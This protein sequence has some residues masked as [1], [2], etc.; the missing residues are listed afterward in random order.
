MVVDLVYYIDDDAGNVS[1]TSLPLPEAFTLAQLTEFAQGFAPIIDAIIH[2]R[3]KGADLCVNINVGGLSNNNISTISDVEEI[4]A[5]EFVTVNGDRV[6][7]NVPGCPDLAVLAGSNEL[8][9]ADAEVAA[10]ITMMESGLAVTSGTKEP[11]DVGASDIV[12]TLFAREH[13]RSSGR[14]R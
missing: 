8:D 10:V 14:R 12:D 7:L 6:K 11:C 13:F 9:T 3:F 4:A 5:F 1:T 2:G